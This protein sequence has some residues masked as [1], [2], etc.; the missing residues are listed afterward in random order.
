MSKNK[1][2]IILL[3]GVFLY[4]FVLQL[5]AIWAF[6]I[7]DMYISLRYAKNWVTSGNLLWN[8]QAEPVEG[9]SN[10]SFVV[11]AA[12]ALILG[13][14][15]V[16]ML[17]LT[18]VAGLLVTLLALYGLSR[19]WFSRWLAL[20]PCFW[21]LLYS[22]QIIWTAS[23]LET[24]LYQ[25][26]ITMSLFCILRANGYGAYSNPRL[27]NQD[28]YFIGS[29][30]LLGLASLTRPEAPFFLCLFFII[31]YVDR[32]ADKK[33]TLSGL[34]LGIIS[35]GLIFIPYFLWRWYY[36]SRL[37][38][39]PIYCKGYSTSFYLLV[40][41]HYL[42]LAWPFLLL[43]L[44]V[45]WQCRDK[46]HYYFWLPSV[47]YL[48][49]LA[50][51]DPL[52]NFANRLFLPAFTLLLPLAWLGIKYIVAYSIDEN[53]RGFTMALV[54][55]G[56]VFAYFFIPAMSLTNYRYFTA[57]PIRG[58]HLRQRVVA[59]LEKNVPAGSDVVLADS[60]MIPYLSNLTFTDSYCLNNKKMTEQPGGGMYQH[61]CNEVL[62]RRVPVI[63]LTSLIEKGKVTYTPADACLYSRLVHNKMYKYRASYQTGN[64]QSS[65]RYEIYTVLN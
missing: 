10:F 51:S 57:N 13:I 54:I 59:W 7:D 29:G 48:V 38:P 56:L 45:L 28:S 3:L 58:E 35:F 15:P 34:T 65:Y 24:T 19:F 14:D 5:A 1:A 33:K 39:N 49:L 53:D 26:L 16:L 46:R 18:G 27:S 41:K 61:F 8:T 20:M 30:I 6:T 43:A 63:I 31:A 11:L 36:F 25:A 62:E 37:F 44:P 23:G 42:H 12:L 2:L 50:G 22:G 47:L 55:I 4:L 32:L 9:Y 21:V 40:D 17:K 60:G 52:V 64:Q